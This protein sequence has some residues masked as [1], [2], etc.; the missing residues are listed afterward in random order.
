MGAKGRALARSRWS[1]ATYGC[2]CDGRS[3]S[4]K[5]LIRYKNYLQ[6]LSTLYLQGAFFIENWRSAILHSRRNEVTY[7][8]LCDGRSPSQGMFGVK[9]LTDV[10]AYDEGVANKR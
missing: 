10:D 5:T 1:K 3:P 7:G 6:V 2:G 4:L 9:R 8:Y